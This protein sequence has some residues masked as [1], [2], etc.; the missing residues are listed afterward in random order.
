MRTVPVEAATRKPWTR[1]VRISTRLFVC[2]YVYP[3]VLGMDSLKD[4][5]KEEAGLLPSLAVKARDILDK[6]LTAEN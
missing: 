1:N 2:L 6:Y 3:L 4:L 5:C